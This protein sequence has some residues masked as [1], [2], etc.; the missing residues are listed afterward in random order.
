MKGS[1]LILSAFAAGL[2]LAA[3]GILPG[4]EY[5]P[6][7]SKYLLYLLMLL[8][9]IGLGLDET[10]A[11][12]LRSQPVRLL[13]LPLATIIGTLAGAAAAALVLRMLYAGAPPLSM[14][15]S[16]SVGCGFG[17]YSLSSIFLNEVRGAELGTIALTANIVRELLTI[18]FAPWM[19]RIFGPLAPISSGGATTMDTTLPI[20]QKTSGNAFVPVSIFHGVA[21]D[22]SV[23]LF[24]TF[25]I[26]FY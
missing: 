23:P 14:L 21:M 5:L 6:H 1:L 10:L 12:T 24:L 19:A 26:S 20:I 17:Y 9:G 13:L 22:F 4:A 11:A 15:D 2:L 18:L 7:Y 3:G 8:V 16:L 25:F